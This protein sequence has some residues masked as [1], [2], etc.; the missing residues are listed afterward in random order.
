MQDGYVR[1]LFLKPHIGAALGKTGNAA[2]SFADD[3]IAVRR[4]EIEQGDFAAEGLP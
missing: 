1:R 4:I 3:A 2:R